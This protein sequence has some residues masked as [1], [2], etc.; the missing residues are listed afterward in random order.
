[1]PK[2]QDESLPEA[3]MIPSEDLSPEAVCEGVAAI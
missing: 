1:M 2:R 3:L